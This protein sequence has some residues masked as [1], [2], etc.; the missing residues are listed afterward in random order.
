MSGMPPGG[1]TLFVKPAAVEII[2][3][4][5]EKAALMLF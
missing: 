3:V 1:V 4:P 5:V 2:T